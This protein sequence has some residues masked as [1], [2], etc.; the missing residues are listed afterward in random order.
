MH[1]VKQVGPKRL[2]RYFFFSLWQVVFDLLTFSP[3]RIF[4]LNL[5]GANISPGTIVDKIDF[6]NLDRTGLKG[7]T[8]GKNCFLGRGALIDLADKV[9]LKNQVIISPRVTVLSHMSVGATTHP[10]YKKYPPISKPTLFKS[11]SFVGA[12]STIL[13][14]VSVGSQSVVAAGSTVTKN[15]PNSVLVAGVPAQTIKK[16]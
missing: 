14:G 10:L 15:I 1:L 3:L 9:T 4:W 6:I 2:L 13:A 16:I 5:F 11:S 8:I 7:L 12:S